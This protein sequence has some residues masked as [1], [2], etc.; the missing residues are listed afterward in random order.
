MNHV[1]TYDFDSVMTI[2]MLK[3]DL[4]IACRTKVAELKT[5]LTYFNYNKL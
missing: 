1:L 3:P 4:Y 5:N 2:F